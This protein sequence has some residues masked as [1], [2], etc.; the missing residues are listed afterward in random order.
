MMRQRSS[1]FARVSR[2]LAVALALAVAGPAIADHYPDTRKSAR[3]KDQGLLDGLRRLT[4]AD[5]SSIT[6]GPFLCGCLEPTCDGGFM[7]GCG[8]R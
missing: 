6:V 2:G 8:A 4:Y 1:S 3:R 5:S 7:L